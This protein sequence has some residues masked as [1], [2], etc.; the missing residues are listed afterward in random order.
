MLATGLTGL[1]DLPVAAASDSTPVW[2]HEAAP[3]R[4]YQD[5][6]EQIMGL[7]KV[8]EG[9]KINVP[10]NM[11]RMTSTGGQAFDVVDTSNILFICGGTFDG[12]EDIIKKRLGLDAD[13]YTILQILSLTLF[14]KTPLLQLLTGA[15]SISGEIDTPNQLNLFD[16]LPGH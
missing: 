12:L 16:N 2:Y 13:L 1:I 11:Q 9:S 4:S 3:S 6:E 10:R 15:E 5:L 8:I 7:L 14:E